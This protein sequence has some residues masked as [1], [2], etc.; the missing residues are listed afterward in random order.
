ADGKLELFTGFWPAFQSGYNPDDY[1][2][3]FR[4]IGTASAPNLTRVAF[5]KTG[6][7]PASFIDRPSVMDWNN[8]GELDLMTSDAP[9]AL[10]V[11]LNDG[12]TS[13]PH[14]SMNYLELKT[15]WGFVPMPPF[16]SVADL[17]HNG[18]QCQLAASTVYVM[19]G[20]VHTP[21]VV[22]KGTAIAD[23]A[24]IFHPGPGYGDAY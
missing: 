20:S 12:T 19:Q 9:G 23:G 6:A 21:H 17:D 14:W 1:L 16:M 7:F 10:K 11:F 4:N 15:P 13:A 18:Q 3:Y 24:P 2:E 5:P 8:D 22:V